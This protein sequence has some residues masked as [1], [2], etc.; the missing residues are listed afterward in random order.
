M[1]FVDKYDTILTISMFYIVVFYLFIDRRHCLPY[2]FEKLT[3][4]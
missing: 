3:Y 4:I 1:E 2:A